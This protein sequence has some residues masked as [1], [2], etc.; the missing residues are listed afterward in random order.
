MPPANLRAVAHQCADFIQALALRGKLASKGMAE[1]Q[2]G[3]DKPSG[4]GVFDPDGAGGLDAYDRLFLVQVPEP[5]TLSLLAIG[6]LALIRRRR[7]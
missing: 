4:I 2:A 6:G 7:S 3:P 1:V 5:A